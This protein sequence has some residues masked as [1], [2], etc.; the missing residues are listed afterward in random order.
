M[1]AIGE[2]TISIVNDGATGSQGPQGTSVTKVVREYTKSSSPTTLPT[3][4]NWT[5][6]EPAIGSNEYLWARDRTDLSNGTST[7]GDAI[8]STNI[9]GI[10]HDVDKANKSITDKVWESD[11]TTKINQYDG[12]TVSTIRDRVTS[13]EQNIS[14]IT[15]RVSDVESS[16]TDEANQRKATYGTCD[17]GAETAAK[18]VTCENFEL[19][20]GS[21]ISVKFTNTNTTAS[22]TLNV[23]STGAKAIKSYTGQDLTEGEYKWAAGSV[24]DF[25]YDGQYWRLSDSGSLKRITSAESSITQNAA[26][27]ELKV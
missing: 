18:A 8:C 2:Y 3:N 13:T 22:P 9:S 1:I 6:T 12:S 24:Y 27:I 25:I 10:K 14:G 16:V 4:P 20:A 21:T 26:N 7:Y 23:N 15:S 19:H 11:I 17:T 5:E